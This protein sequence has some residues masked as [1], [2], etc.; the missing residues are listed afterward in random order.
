MICTSSGTTFLWIPVLNCTK[1]TPSS[2]VWGRFSLSQC[3]P[4]LAS[5]EAAQTARQAVSEIQV[6][7]ITFQ[8]QSGLGWEA[9]LEVTVPSPAQSK[10]GSGPPAQNLKISRIPASLPSICSHPLWKCFPIYLLAISLAATHSY[11]LSGYTCNL[12][13]IFCYWKINGLPGKLF[14]W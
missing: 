1:T 13:N 10:G 5:P 4:S 14:K 9:S 11:C 2:C 3:S 12:H 7:L 6:E 8:I